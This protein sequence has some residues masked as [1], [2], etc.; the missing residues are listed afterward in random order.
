MNRYEGFE[1]WEIGSEDWRTVEGFPNYEI[2]SLGQ[3]RNVSTRTILRPARNPQNGRLYVF[4]PGRRTLYLHKAV[5]AAFLPPQPP[6]HELDHN[7]GNKRNNRATNLE[8]VTHAENMR[9][10]FALR[11][12]RLSTNRAP[13]TAGS[14]S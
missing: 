8:W 13:S 3:I 9:R 11:E 10:Y 4:L 12:R 2:S 6:G 7:D 14:S 1:W 5:A